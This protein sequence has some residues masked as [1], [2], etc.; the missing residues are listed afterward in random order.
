ML[1]GHLREPS[2]FPLAG[3]FAALQRPALPLRIAGSFWSSSRLVT[4][5]LDSV[6]AEL[7]GQRA[8]TSSCGVCT[9]D[10]LCLLRWG[11]LPG[12]GEDVNAKLLA[13]VDELERAVVP[14]R[15]KSRVPRVPSD[16]QALSRWWQRL[17]KMQGVDGAVLAR[18]VA[19]GLQATRPVFGPGGEV[20]VVP[21]YAVR[22]QYFV[23]AAKV[24]GIYPHEQDIT[25]QAAASAGGVVVRL[26]PGLQAVSPDGEAAV[27]I[28]YADEAMNAAGEE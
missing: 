23:E 6:P 22:R 26:T 19:E 18:V 5:S 11:I 27:D 12:M 17:L 3:S 14:A 4:V 25:V 15:R 10:S 24:M 8:H 7:Y 21:D 20:E 1:T 9:G 2:A 13:A 16:R 28:A